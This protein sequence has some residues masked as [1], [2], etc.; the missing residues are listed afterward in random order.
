VQGW[1]EKYI[2]FSISNVE[3]HSGSST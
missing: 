1:K 2:L 3:I